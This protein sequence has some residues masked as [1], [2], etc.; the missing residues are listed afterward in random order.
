MAPLLQFLSQSNLIMKPDKLTYLVIENVIDVCEGIERRMSAF[1][2]WQSLGYCTGIREA[3][4]KIKDTMPNL[5]YLDWGLNGGSAFEILQQIQNIPGYNPYILFNTGFQKDNP[6][7]PQEIVNNYKVDKYLVKPLWENLRNNLPAYLKEAEDKAAK[8]EEKSKTVWLVDSKGIQV[9]IALDK[10]ICI[11]QH[12]IEPRNRILYIDGAVKEIIVPIQWQKC[13]EL[14]SQNNIDYFVTKFRSHLVTRAYL[15][16]Y[17]RPFI[18]LRKFPAKVE[19]V[20]ESLKEF[21]N[22]LLDKTILK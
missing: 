8:Q 1:P 20:K 13:Y 9:Q 18:R 21:E 12:P 19:V 10:I 11:C 4:E 3:I 16:T 17:K 15:E 14:L 5:I 6:E 22:W 2:G 7:I